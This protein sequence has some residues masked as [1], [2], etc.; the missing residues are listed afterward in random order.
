MRAPLLVLAAALLALWLVASCRV[1]D[2]RP[3][4]L[5]RWWRRRR[6]RALYPRLS[7]GVGGAVVDLNARRVAALRRRAG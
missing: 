3:W 6:V 7:A 2:H 1:V 4:P 5:V